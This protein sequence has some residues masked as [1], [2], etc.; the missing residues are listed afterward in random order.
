MAE[1]DEALTIEEAAARL[2]VDPATVQ[3]E[4]RAGRLPG[5]KVGNKIWRIPGAA[6]SAYLKG[7]NRDPRQAI[8]YA[9]L[10]FHIGDLSTGVKTLV[11]AA[12]YEQ[13]PTELR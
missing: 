8:D 9:A 2:K 7:Q 5:T 11:G 4:L 6:L 1:D 12:G 3:R 10:S 13:M